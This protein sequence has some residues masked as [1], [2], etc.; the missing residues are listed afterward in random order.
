[1]NKKTVAIFGALLGGL[2]VLVYGCAS[3]PQYEPVSSH[4]SGPHLEIATKPTE[5]AASAPSPRLFVATPEQQKVYEKVWKAKPAPAAASQAL[6]AG[7][8][9]PRDIGSIPALPPTAGGQPSR[10]IGDDLVAPTK[11]TAVAAVG[12]LDN[13]WDRLGYRDGMLQYRPFIGPNKSVDMTEQVVKIPYKCAVMIQGTEH[14][15]TVLVQTAVSPSRLWESDFHRL[16]AVHA[17]TGTKKGNL[18]TVTGDDI[19]AGALVHL[20][21]R[22]ERMCQVASKKSLSALLDDP[23]AGF[24]EELNKPDAGSPFLVKVQTTEVDLPKELLRALAK[25]GLAAVATAPKKVAPKPMQRPPQQCCSACGVP[26]ACLVDTK[27]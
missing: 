3:Q 21:Q 4:G 25:K 13:W 20:G 8:A 2:T 15:V 1:M 24:A 22:Q 11:Q 26:A 5:E 7:P 18:N 14:L 12:S 17:G 16:V 6:A 10:T 19:M 27:Q 9:L 23:T